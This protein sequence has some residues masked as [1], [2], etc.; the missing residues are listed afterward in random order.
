MIELGLW[1]AVNYFPV[2]FLTLKIFWSSKDY[3]K[4]KKNPAQIDLQHRGLMLMFW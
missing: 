1:K 4:K 2:T 3:V